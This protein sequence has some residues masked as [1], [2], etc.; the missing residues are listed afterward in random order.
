MKL[1]NKVLIA[2]LFIAMLGGKATAKGIVTKVYMFGFAA[3]FTDSIVH[4]TNIQ[5]VDSAW[6]DQKTKFLLGRDNYSYQLKSY[7]TEKL[8]MPHRTCIVVF[9]TDRAKLEKE[10]VKMK[11]LYTEKKALGKY[12]VKYLEESSFKFTPV[13]AGYEEVEVEAE[14]EQPEK[15][16]GKPKKKGPKPAGKPDK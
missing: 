1:T 9:N 11:R 13:F 6:T 12:D 14:Q 4:F 7:L 15:P 8:S 10:Y 5:A 2:M 3:S 16:A